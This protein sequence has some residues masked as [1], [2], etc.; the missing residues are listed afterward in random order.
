MVDSNP[1]NK[2]NTERGLTDRGREQVSQAVERLKKLGV[3]SPRVFYDNGVRASQT[4]DIIARELEVPRRDVEPE[5]RWL[6]ARGLGELDGTDL[7][8]ATATLRALDKVDIDNEPEPTDDGTPAD[9]V[10]E[11]YSRLGNTIAKIENTYGAGDFIIVGGDGDVLS[12]L[13]A[14]ACG[15]D[16]REHGRFALAPG[17]FWDLRELVR[18]YRAGSFAG[19]EPTAVPAWLPSE[20]EAKAGREVLADIGSKLF[21]D[22]AAGSCLCCDCFR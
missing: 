6:E 5:F 4:A 9:S 18:E 15:V 14:A 13:A 2:G 20:A 8:K 11:V 3:N 22:T 19:P 16:L 12:I 10:N 1:I 21:S 7:A 17:D